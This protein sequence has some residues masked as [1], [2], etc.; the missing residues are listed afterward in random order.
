M[1]L[2]TVLFWM[3]RKVFVHIPPGGKEFVKEAFSKEGL[4]VILRLLIIYAFVAIFWALF[5]QTG[6]SWVLQADQMEKT[7]MGM[8]ILPSLLQAANPFLILILVPLFSYVVYPA[9]DKVFKLT[10]LRKIGIGLFITAA[11]FGASAVIEQ[12]IVAGHQPNI[13]WQIIPYIII[14]A[15]EVMVSITC[16]EF[17][18]TQAPRTMKSLIMAIFLLSVTMGN[19]FTSFVNAFIEQDDG[20]VLLEGASYYW[21]FSGVMAVTA[22]VFVFVAMVYKEKTYMQEEVA[23]DPA[24]ADH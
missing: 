15:G 19:L 6:S 13:M 2:A 10:P 1:L 11:S 4:S 23:V 3:G 24:I 12:F 18:Y 17:S 9:I 22:L 8:E 5:D 21:F 14:T 20:T 16:L 7:F